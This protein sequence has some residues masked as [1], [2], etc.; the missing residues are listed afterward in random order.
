MTVFQ[1]RIFVY[2]TQVLMLVVGIVGLR[3]W[4]RLPVP[5]R[6]L[7]SYILFM[8][9]IVIVED[10]LA[11]SNIRSL[12]IGH[13]STVIELL[14]FSLIYYYWR[15]NKQYGKLLWSAY[16]V[17]LI[18]WII[19]KFTFEPFYYSDVY[20]GSVSQIIQ[21]VFGGWLLYSISREHGFEWKK[22]YRFLVVS[23]IALY[24]AASFFL[25]TSFNLML[26][27]PRPIMRLVWTLNLVFIVIQYIFFLRGFLCKTPLPSK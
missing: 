1:G 23:G 24:A 21:I 13:W 2:I 5:L 17:Y 15:P 14:F 6:I 11:H 18:I 20:S 19:G 10:I 25:L 27:L 3:E 22:D 16:P 8:L 26:T 12:W 7:E 9:A 4:K